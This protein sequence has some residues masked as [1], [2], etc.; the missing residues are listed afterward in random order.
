MNSVGHRSEQGPF[1]LGE[2]QGVHAERVAI[3]KLTKDDLQDSTIYTTLEP[4]VAVQP[5][6]TLQSVVPT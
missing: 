2:R 6:Q 3:E 1:V 4:C 5:G